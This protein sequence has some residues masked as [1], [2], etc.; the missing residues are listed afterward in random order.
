MRRTIGMD[1]H[2]TFGEVVFWENGRLR[3]AGRV[4]MTRTALE[5]FG[6]TFNR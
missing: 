2:E 1:I 6:K 3:P 5:G 4:D